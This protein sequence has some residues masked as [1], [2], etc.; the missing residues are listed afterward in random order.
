M[1]TAWLG[2]IS[3]L[4]LAL[5]QS[6]IVDEQTANI[7]SYVSLL[8][9]IV[10]VL[11]ICF[12]HSNN[13]YIDGVPELSKLSSFEVKR[14]LEIIPITLVCNIAFNVPYNATFGPLQS[15]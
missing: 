1:L 12:G 11:V 6:F 4:I 7:V 5:V 10:S 2:L 8:I 9:G 13:D 14:A 3:F 15:Q